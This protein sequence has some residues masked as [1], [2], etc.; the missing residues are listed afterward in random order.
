MQ[1]AVLKTES[2]WIFLLSC[3]PCLSFLDNIQPPRSVAR[4]LRTAV[5]I[6]LLIQI[7]KM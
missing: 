7:G 1:E 4:E 5:Q 6:L 2:Q 3:L